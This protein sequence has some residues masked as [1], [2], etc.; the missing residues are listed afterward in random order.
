MSARINIKGK[1]YGN[2]YVQEFAYAQNTHA[3]WQVKCMLCD[4]IFYATYTN[5]NSGNTTACSGCNVIGLSREIR[6]DIVQ[7]KANK[8]SIVSIAKYY[9]ISRSKVYSVLRRMS[10]D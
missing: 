7:R 8:E 2:L 4:K 9:Q 3:Y 10:K 5:L 6:D 1:T